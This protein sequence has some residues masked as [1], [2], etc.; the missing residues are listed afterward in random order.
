MPLTE[1]HRKQIIHAFCIIFYLLLLLKLWNGFLLYQIKPILFNTRFDLVTWLVMKTGIHQ[2][3][4]NNPF[5]WL[6]FDITFYLIPLVYLLAY[7]RSIRL[8]S[9]VAIIMLIVNYIY[10]QCYTLYPANSIEG[11]IPW[12]LF[13][14]LLMAV[15]LRS[16][17]FILHALRYFFLF[18]FVSAAIWKFV[19]GGVFNINQ[20][21]GVLLFQHKEYLASS[22]N[23]WYTYFIYWL[24]SHRYM[25][26]TL[27][28]AATFL[29]L[30]FITGFFTKRFDRLLIFACI[31]F[32][33]TDLF[34]MRIPYWEITPFLITLLFSKYT[35]PP[36]QYQKN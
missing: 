15:N 7:K 12:L 14:F 9:V 32:L 36:V 26:Y 31:I 23:F 13:P 18:F 29:E 30:F 20:M 6:A 33:L 35:L 5:G 8:A 24:V 4:L 27:Y 1:Q 25:G 2:W 10:I 16:F 3:L 11:F 22:P 28:V 34:F 19:Q 17:Y 21:S